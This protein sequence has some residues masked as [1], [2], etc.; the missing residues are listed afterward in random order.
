MHGTGQITRSRP[1]HREPQLVRS[2]RRYFVISPGSIPLNRKV[3]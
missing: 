2:G 3:K 1:D